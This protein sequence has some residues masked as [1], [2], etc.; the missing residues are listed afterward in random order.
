LDLVAP[1]I[2]NEVAASHSRDAMA[3]GT[4]DGR[5]RI[6]KFPAVCGG[7]VDYK[8]HSERVVRLAWSKDDKLLFTVGGYD[9]ALIIWKVAL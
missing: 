9:K 2:V 5:V 3:T 1:D 7:F 6:Y 8:A 4:E